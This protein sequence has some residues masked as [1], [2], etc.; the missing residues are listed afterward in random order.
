LKQNFQGDSNGEENYKGH[1]VP[2]E[3]AFAPPNPEQMEMIM[4]KYKNY[5][6]TVGG[7][8]RDRGIKTK[9]EVAFGIPAEAI[10]S[11]ADSVQADLV[12]MSTHGLSGIGR[13]ALGSTAD[14]VLH[15]GNTPVLLVRPH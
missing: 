9:S 11:T 12:A 13:W 2:E 5:L 14:K 10:I 6:E 4:T 3:A 7:E 1:S 15:A 8:F